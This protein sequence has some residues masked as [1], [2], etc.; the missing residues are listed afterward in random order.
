VRLRLRPINHDFHGFYPL[1]VVPLAIFPVELV[2]GATERLGFNTVIG[3]MLAATSWR[4]SFGARA[5]VVITKQNRLRQKALAELEAN[6]DSKH[7]NH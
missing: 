1:D 3:G 7:E 5:L 6:Y 2:P 4:S